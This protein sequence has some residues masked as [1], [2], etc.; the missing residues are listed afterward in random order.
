MEQAEPEAG[1]SK[2]GQRVHIRDE[3]ER[4]NGEPAAFAPRGGGP[5]SRRGDVQHRMVEA[6]PETEA[7]LVTLLTDRADDRFGRIAAQ[8][9]Q[10][11]L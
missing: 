5:P 4:R 6:P 2:Y 8:I 9:G 10:G 3:I 7:E 1:R 11:K